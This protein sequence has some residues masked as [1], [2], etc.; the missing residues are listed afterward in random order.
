VGLEVES[1]EN[2][3]EA[4]KDFVVAEVRDAQQHPNADRLK[5]CK[6]WDG[7]KELNI[8]CG[9]PNARAGIKV[10]LAN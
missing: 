1:V 9:A 3:T 10:V 7:K 5:V 4:L 8:V 6:V 2:P